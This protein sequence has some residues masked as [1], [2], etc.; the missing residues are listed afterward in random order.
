[1]RHYF[2]VSSWN[3]PDALRAIADEL[4]NGR[5]HVTVDHIEFKYN[6]AVWSCYQFTVHYD[7]PEHVKDGPCP[8]CASEGTFRTQKQKLRRRQEQWEH[9]MSQ[10]QHLRAA[11]GESEV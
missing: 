11:R 4:D 8:A 7:G 9:A 1:M 6:P 5:R 10:G 3:L 2:G